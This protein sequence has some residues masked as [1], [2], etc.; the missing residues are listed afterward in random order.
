[1]IREWT[2]EVPK[3]LNFIKEKENM[4][5]VSSNILPYYKNDNKNLRFDVSIPKPIEELVTEKVLVMEY[6]DG[7][8]I[9]KSTLDKHSISREDVITSIT[10]AYGHMIFVDGFY[11]GKISS[12]LLL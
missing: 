1:M 2:R 7:F 6:I 3:E 10:R 9:D 11:Q 8:K 4:L 5:R 12:T